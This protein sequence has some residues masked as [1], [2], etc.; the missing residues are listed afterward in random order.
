MSPTRQA[1]RIVAFAE[2]A[3]L[4]VLLV[5]LATVHWQPISSLVGPTHGCAYLLVVILTWRQP[6]AG[7]RTKAVAVLPVVGGLLVLRRL[8][9]ERPAT[10][11]GDRSGDAAAPRT[12]L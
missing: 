5:N 6:G 9:D 4:L 11:P 2:P 8:P 3:T 7:P 1:L 12:D 10:E